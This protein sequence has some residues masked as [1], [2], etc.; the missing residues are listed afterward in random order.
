[1]I[2]VYDMEAQCIMWRKLN[3]IFEKKELGM[4]ISRGSWRLMCKQAGML[5]ALFM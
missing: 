2:V 5:F 4:H 3:A 1:M